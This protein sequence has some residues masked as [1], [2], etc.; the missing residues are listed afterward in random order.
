MN[1]VGGGIVCP[2]CQATN[3]SIA[4]FCFACG[5]SLRQAGNRLP[6]QAQGAAQIQP[7]MPAEA[8]SLAHQVS[9]HY[10]APPPVPAY[11]AQFAPPAPAQAAPTQYAPQYVPPQPYTSQYQPATAAYQYPPQPAPTYNEPPTSAYATYAPG[12]AP[13]SINVSPVINMQAPVTMPTPP[14]PIVVVN[15]AAEPSLVVRVLWDVAPVRIMLPA[16]GR[17]TAAEEWS[18]P[19]QSSWIKRLLCS[20]GAGRGEAPKS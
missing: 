4:A 3:M 16:S 10:Q 7:D 11:P 17:A 15:N 1:E 13:L 20:S 5:M 2:Q 12:M 19:L 14:Q 9:E 18:R 6:D 8:T